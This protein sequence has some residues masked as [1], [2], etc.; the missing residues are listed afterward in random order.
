MEPFSS[1][2]LHRDIVVTPPDSSPE[3]EPWNRYRWLGW[4]W[5]QTEATPSPR[6]ARCEL[7]CS[8]QVTE[9]NG[10]PKPQA[11]KGCPDRHQ[12]P[13][14]LVAFFSLLSRLKNI[15]G[16][17]QQNEEGLSGKSEKELGEEN[18]F[19]RKEELKDTSVPILVQNSPGLCSER[20]LTNSPALHE[21]A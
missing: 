6:A 8:H 3:D 16:E 12:P 7:T 10:S 5:G 20:L 19:A 1:P 9:V 17:T 13:A 14:A 2:H 4:V 21:L 18:N 15:C 11:R